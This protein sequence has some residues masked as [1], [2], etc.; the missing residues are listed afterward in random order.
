[1]GRRKEVKGRE[2]TGRVKQSRRKGREG[3]VR[4]GKG[5]GGKVNTVDKWEIIEWKKDGRGEK[6][7]GGEEGERL[8]RKGR[9]EELSGE[10]RNIE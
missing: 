9:M 7:G 1:M 8:E 5:R 4:R 2:R 6:E 3:K 10:V